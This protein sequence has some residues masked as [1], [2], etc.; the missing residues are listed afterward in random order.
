[1]PRDVPCGNSSIEN[2]PR[3]VFF[4]TM[5]RVSSRYAANPLV[6]NPLRDVVAK[7]IDFK[8]VRACKSMELFISATN[9]E[10]G[11]LR[12]F[13]DGEIDLDTV[14]ASACLPQLF[15]AVEIKGVPYWD[16]GY[17]GYPALDPFFM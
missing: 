3:Y 9:V 2:T 6:L 16:G 8:N 10:T 17:G 13:S 12:V 4:H 1:M 11:Q 15:R 7:E 14:M 5:S